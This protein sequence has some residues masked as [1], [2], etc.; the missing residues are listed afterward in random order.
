MQRIAIA[1]TLLRNPSIIIFDEATSALDAESEYK[2][3]E[4]ISRL[5]ST[6]TVIAIAHRLSTIKSADN[7]MVLDE[8]R[9]VEEGQFDQLIERK[10]AFYKFYWRQF[11]GLAAFRQHLGMEFERTARYGSKFCLAI[12]E[13]RKYRD[14]ENKDGT[15]AAEEF[16]EAADFLIKKQVRLGDN[17]A[18][19]DGDTI[20]LLLPEIDNDQ[21]KQF[22]N[23]MRNIIP[24]DGDET[25][26]YPIKVDE[27][28]FV[29]TRITH[30]GFKTPEDLLSELKKKADN[31]KKSIDYEIITEEDLL[32]GVE[33]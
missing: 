14:I 13:L 21:L 33:K 1:R 3:H 2:I 32:E 4:V 11:G 17:C 18:R 27:L 25:V 19:L 16:A 12:L 23:R 29:G 8:G 9:F 5:R 6:K 20:L 15:D 24:R 30:K 10:G 7:I 31:L 22:F 26:K 28:A